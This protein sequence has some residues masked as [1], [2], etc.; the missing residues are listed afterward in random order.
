MFRPIAAVFL[1]ACAAW[2][3][4]NF[5]AASVKPSAPPPPDGGGFRI[6]TKGGPGT[7]TPGIF[8]TENYP[9]SGLVTMAYDV[10]RYQVTLPGWMDTERFE[11]RANV[12]EGATKEQFRTMLQNLL[13]ERFKLTVHHENKE[14]PGYELVTGKS[15]P[16]FKES[17]EATANTP[18][19]LAPASGGPKLDAEGF[20]ILPPG[21]SQIVVKGR[22]RR[23]TTNET[24]DKFV[25]FLSNQV[26][27]PVAD[28]TGLKG[29]YDIVLAW[30]VGA[31]S[32]GDEQGISIF[33]AVQGLGLKLVP[34]TGMVEMLV[35]DHAEKL[36]VAN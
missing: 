33:T 13:A 6:T 34:K 9:I 16:R 26:G 18:A 28:A 5:E 15:G 30:S 31:P 14:M 4:T 19:T 36:P 25:T 11:I 7:A 2:A 21:V 29:K 17:A 1:A 12:P 23:Q 27:R 24:M 10:K 22:A 32:T 8:T 35:V 3:Q 20:P